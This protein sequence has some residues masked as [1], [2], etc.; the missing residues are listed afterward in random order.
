MTFIKS[1]EKAIDIL[2]CFTLETPVLKVVEIS[3]LTGLTQSTVSRILATLAKKNC[4]EQIGPSGKYRLGIKFYQWTGVLCHK[5]NLADLARPVMEKLGDLCGEEVTLHGL[6]E[7]RRICFAAVKSRF[8][9]AKVTPVGKILPLHCGA[10]GKVLLAFLP[11]SERKKIISGKGLEQFTSETII[12][13][14][15]LEKD[16]DLIRRDGYAVSKGEREEGAYSIV[17]PIFDRN[18]NIAASLSISGPVF[19]L[20]DAELERNVGAVRNAAKEI[21]TVLR[22]TTD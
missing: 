10:G 2:S 4:L 8:G 1:V 13:P 12:D 5:K 6:D 21:S 15:L 19:R 11:L 14:V 3:H 17:A 20:S 18:G 9:V 22:E 7:N 16:L